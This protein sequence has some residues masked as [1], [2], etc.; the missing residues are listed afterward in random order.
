MPN[1]NNQASDWNYDPNDPYSPIYYKGAVVGFIKPEYAIR[2]VDFLNEDERL[3][4]ALKMACFDLITEAGGDTS[5]VDLLMRKYIASTERPRYGSAAVALLLRDRQD[6]LD[7]SDKE[8]ARFCDSYRLSWK[9]LKEIFLGK[10]INDNQLGPIARIVGKS[11]EEL[12]EVRDGPIP[13]G[14]R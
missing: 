14:D 1:N 2:I 11:I 8:F 12:I 13:R 3:R 7:I 9:E 5:R 4:K 6:E 10:D